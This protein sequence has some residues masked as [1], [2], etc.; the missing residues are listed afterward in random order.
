MKTTP[1]FKKFSLHFFQDIDLVVG[2][3]EELY[4]FVLGPFKGAERVRLRDFLDT[5]TQDSVSDEARQTL[6]WASAAEVA[7]SDGADLRAVLKRAR[8]RL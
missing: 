2:T 1:E 7:F 8:D 6:W 4:A 5:V 3:E